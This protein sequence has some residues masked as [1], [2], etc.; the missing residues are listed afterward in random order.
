MGTCGWH[1]GRRNWT[2]AYPSAIAFQIKSSLEVI[3]EAG[4]R[5]KRVQQNA[6]AGDVL[7]FH[8]TTDSIRRHV[9]RTAAASG[10]D[11]DCQFQSARAIAFRH[12]AHSN[13][14]ADSAAFHSTSE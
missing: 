14:G 7:D 9:L 3:D 12:S 13:V 10:L 5:T 4:G 6:V 11:G 8:W 1:T 2:I